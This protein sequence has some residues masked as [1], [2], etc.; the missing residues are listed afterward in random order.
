M[1]RQRIKAQTMADEK[2]LARVHDKRQRTLKAR[3]RSTGELPLEV[4]QAA[5]D[6]H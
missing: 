5:A 1:S 3:L 2:V 6:V 4:C